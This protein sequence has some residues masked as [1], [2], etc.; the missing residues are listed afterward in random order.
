MG[1]MTLNDA[2]SKVEEATGLC[3][4]AELGVPRPASLISRIT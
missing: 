2:K 4:Y 1:K 3:P